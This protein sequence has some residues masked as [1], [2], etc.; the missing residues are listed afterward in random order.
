MS[1]PQEPFS[2]EVFCRYYL[3]FE[4]YK[5]VARPEEKEKL[6]QYMFRKFNKT[7]DYLTKSALMKT[8]LS[9]SSDSIPD[10]VTQL[11]DSKKIALHKYFVYIANAR[12]DEM[13]RLI[14]NFNAQ[15]VSN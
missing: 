4:R 11:L 15:C 3:A 12:N 9:T 1:L 14:T 10:I 6:L 13:T 2:E 7:E 8:V 5:E